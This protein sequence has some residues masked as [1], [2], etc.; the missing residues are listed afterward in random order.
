MAP[1][2]KGFVREKPEEL[3]VMARA[4]ETFGQW[5]SELLSQRVSQPM[6]YRFNLAAAETLWK[7][8]IENAKRTEN[9]K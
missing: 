6:A 7:M 8:A 4:A 2:S 3:L 5:P 1:T 9:E